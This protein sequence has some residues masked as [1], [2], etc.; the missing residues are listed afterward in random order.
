[1]SLTLERI[2]K[3]FG[4]LVAFFAIIGIQ[5]FIGIAILSIIIVPITMIYS[6]MT[7]RSYNLVMDSSNLLYKLN[8]LGQWTIEFVAGLSIF[9]FLILSKI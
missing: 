8:K 2:L 4:L 1:M 5:I 9:W 3:I 7:G 6:K